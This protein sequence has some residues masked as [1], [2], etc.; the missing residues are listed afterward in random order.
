MLY[1]H[2]VIKRDFIHICAF[3]PSLRSTLPKIKKMYLLIALAFRGRLVFVVV[4][5]FL[6]LL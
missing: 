4:M 2:I 3:R 6:L 1:N 5:V